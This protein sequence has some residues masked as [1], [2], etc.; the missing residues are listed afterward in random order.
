MLV[1]VTHIVQGYSQGITGQSVDMTG[2]DCRHPTKIAS[3]LVNNICKHEKAN[4]INKQEEG[5]ILQMTNF[6]LYL[7]VALLT[8]AEALQDMVDPTG[9]VCVNYYVFGV[10]AAPYRG[11]S[12]KGP[13]RQRSLA[14]QVL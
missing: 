12:M 6:A 11:L 10:A 2:L 5:L 7:P 3:S 13:A 4:N 1:I 9:T 8:T 14:L